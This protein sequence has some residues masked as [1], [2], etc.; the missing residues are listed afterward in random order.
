MKQ[1]GIN[2]VTMAVWDLDQGKEF[3]ANLLGAEFESVNDA[4]AEAFGL[5]CAIAW[6]AGVELVAPLEGRDSYVRTLLEKNGE[7]LVGVVFAVDD[8]DTAK[9]AAEAADIPVFHALDYTQAEIDEHLQGRFTKYKEYFLGKGGPLS[10][11]VLI[12]EFE[13]S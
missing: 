12:G 2:R 5:C 7:G 10:S 4:D 6:N 9:R 11:G 13:E 8:A 3:Y 1:R